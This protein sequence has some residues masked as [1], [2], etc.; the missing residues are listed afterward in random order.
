[1]MRS[2]R[3]IKH[4]AGRW[5]L[6]SI[7][8]GD[9]LIVK[10][11]AVPE[12]GIFTVSDYEYDDGYYNK[13]PYDR[14]K[15]KKKRRRKRHHPVLLILLV[16]VLFTVCCEKIQ[17]QNRKVST[18]SSYSRTVSDA[19]AGDGLKAG[20]L[21]EDTKKALETMAKTNPKARP[22]VQNPGQYPERL[23][24]SLG[25]NPEL[26]P[27]TL[28]YPKKKGTFSEKIN[29]SDQCRQGQIPLL[30]Q[31]DEA[32]GY[33]GYGDG[34]IALDGCGPTCLSMVDIGLTGDT[35]KNPRE[36]ADFSE[37]NGYLDQNNSTLWALMTEGAKK[38]GLHSR[39]IPLDESRMETELS[40]GHPIICSMGPGDFTTQGHFIVLYRFQGGKFRIRDP[41]S[42]ERS[43]EGW[44]YKTLKPQIRNLWAFSA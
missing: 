2:G 20:T 13:N 35:S 5:I 22:I 6:P 25:R 24:E 29:L 26:L 19:A 30:L 15:I 28:D 23:L 9:K 16:A 34:I 37:Q 10:F 12:G 36:I 39:E 17:N 8:D 42:R 3:I 14:T 7:E 31:W 41:N 44:S 4:R 38:L 21:P 32:W 40:E 33:A 18:F 1:M 43:G 11:P 27:F